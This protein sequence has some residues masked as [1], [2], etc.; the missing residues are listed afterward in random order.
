MRIAVIDL[1]TNSVRFDIHEII[2]PGFLKCIFRRKEMV[3]LGEGL[4][5]SKKLKDKAMNRAESAIKSFCR[6]MELFQVDRIVAGAT[7]A[8]REARN[9]KNFVKRILDNLGINIR[10]IEGIEEA[11]LILKG[12]ESFEPRA[13]DRFAFVDI[14]GGSTEVGVHSEGET[15]YLDSFP[16][17]A[18]RLAQFLPQLPPSSMEVDELRRAI[19]KELQQRCGFQDWPKVDFLF[20]ASGTVKALVKVMKA[21]GEGRK[22]SRKSLKALVREMSVS[23]IEEIREIPGMEEK[24]SDIILPGSILLE[25]LMDFFGCKTIYRTRYALRE[26]LIQ[27]ELEAMGMATERTEINFKHDDY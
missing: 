2:K 1:G 17:G 15:V 22:V 20:G 18:V 5:Q 21:K 23:S 10:I 16:L 8:T 25:E 19:R 12:I 6:E 7:S 13:E 4:F 24:R 9:G 26:G 11:R 3:R 27:E 14:G